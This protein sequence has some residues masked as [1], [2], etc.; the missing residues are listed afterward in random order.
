MSLRL[1]GLLSLISISV[2]CG[3]GSGPQVEVAPVS[4]VVMVDGKPFPNPIVT[5]HPETGPVGIGLGNENGEFS[6]K[7]NGRNG[8]PLGKCTVTVVGRDGDQMEV[9]PADG[10]EMQLLKKPRLNPKYATQDTTDLFIDVGSE[11][12]E[13]LQ[14]D[15]ESS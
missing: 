15:L 11:G 2:G 4:G 9:P 10:N 1:V 14:L 12:N 7:T 8:A 5:F 3:G 6:I 13:G